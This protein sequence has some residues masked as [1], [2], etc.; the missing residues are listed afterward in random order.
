MS[1]RKNELNSTSQE[2]I[3][4]GADSLLAS[5][6]EL[7]GDIPIISTFVALNTMRVQYKDYMFERKLTQFLYPLSKMSEK[8]R[9]KISEMALDSDEQKRFGNT[10]WVLLEQAED[11]DKPLVMGRLFAAHA[12]GDLALGDLS[13][14]CKMV[15]RCYYEDL[16]LL[17]TFVSGLFPG[18]AEQAQSLA[19]QGF[20]YAVGSDGGTFG[21]DELSS[22]GGTLY[23]L[24]SYGTQLVNYGLD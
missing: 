2:L 13:R 10:L 24:S 14:L 8:E 9:K 17:K 12:K 11:L 1:Q 21:E 23:E 15:Q 19:A 22:K 16:P 6:A 7:S 5:L 3:T 18:R 20:L 4:Q